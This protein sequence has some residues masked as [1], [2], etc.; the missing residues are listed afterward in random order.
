VELKAA[1]DLCNKFEAQLFN[2]LKTTQKNVG[3]LINFGSHPDLKW[4]RIILNQ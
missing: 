2:Y 4:K 3:Y 1:N